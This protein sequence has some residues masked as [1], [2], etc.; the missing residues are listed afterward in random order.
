MFDQDF[1]YVPKY[2]CYISGGSTDSSGSQSSQQGFRDL[3]P[4]IQNVFKTLATQTGSYLNGGSNA[5]GTTSMFTPLAQTAGETGA[6]NNINQGFAP[7]ASSINSDI[8]MQTNPFDSSVIDTINRQAAGQ[9][10]VLNQQT[11]AAGQFGSNRAMLGAN[12]IDLSR[13]EQ[14]GQFKQGEYNTALN[15][16]LTTLPQQRLSDANAQLSAG[17]F[18]RSLNS[19]TQ[20]APITALQSIAQILGTLPTNSGQ[21]AG[22]QQSSGFNFGLFGSDRNIKEN[23]IPLGSERGYPI[24]AFNY[25]GDDQTYAGVMAQDVEKIMPDAVKTIDGIKHVDYSMISV[26]M[27]KL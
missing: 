11:N 8:N 3:P 9:G 20:Q 6:I 24:Y 14:I 26:P 19:Q 2:I 16:A 18:Q 15:N 7:T 5:A 22:S 12:D 25:K 23:I 17:G 10:S 1:N 21:S 13:L 4:E 27:R